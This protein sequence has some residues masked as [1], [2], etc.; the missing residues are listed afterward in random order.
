MAMKRTILRRA[1]MSGFLVISLLLF[2]SPFSFASELDEIRAAIEKEGAKWIARETSISYL[3]PELRRLRVRLIKPEI[4]GTERVISLGPPPLGLP[5]TFDWR[6][7]SGQNYVTGV[8]DQGGCGSCWAFATTG[9]LESY[10]LIQNNLPGQ[11]LDLAEQILVSSCSLSSRAGD[12]NGGYIDRAS[13][14][15]RDTGL[16]LE[17][18]YPYTATYGNCANACSNW[19][20]NTDRIDSWAWVALTSPT[21]DAIKN[22][23]YTYGPLVT[24]M[25]VYDDFWSYSLGIYSRTSVIDEGGHAVLIIGFD[26]TEE[27]FI[28]KNSW[29]TDWGEDGFFRIAYSQL[30]DLVQ[31][32]YYT[33]AYEEVACTYSISPTNKSFSSGGGTGSVSVTAPSGCSWTAASNVNWVTITSSSSGSGKGTVGYSVAANT[34][35]SSQS[36]TMTIA[37]QT[38]TVTQAG[39]PSCTY[40]ISP[41]SKSISSR[42]GTGSVS[43]TAPSGC[44]W[45]ATSNVNW[46]T[47]TSGSSGSGKGTVRYSVAANTS[48]SSQSGTMTIAGQTFTVTQAGAPSCTYSISPTNQSGEEKGTVLF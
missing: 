31:F 8:R 45:T 24:T 2:V 30:S 35:S 29:G 44:S 12:C 36:G 47:I 4:T 13:N 7:F 18:C 23:L 40:S 22:A 46:V 41:T 20:S 17:T 3:P 15:I 16:P 37:G 1:L 25:E 42:G 43:V 38:F 33:I 14:F 10:T 26:D 39:A 32:G 9:A 27:C 48:S 6:N 5:A 11:D 34:N 19:Q 28:A 21:V